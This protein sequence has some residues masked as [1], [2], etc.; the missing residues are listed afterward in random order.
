MIQRL[1]SQKQFHHTDNHVTDRPGRSEDHQREDNHF[2]HPL[3]RG[4]DQEFAGEVVELPSLGFSF[5]TI[6]RPKATAPLADV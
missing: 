1:T 2:F 6:E 3:A 4:F 5:I